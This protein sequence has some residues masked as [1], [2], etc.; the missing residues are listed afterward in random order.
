MVEKRGLSRYFLFEKIKSKKSQMA[1]FIIVALVLIGAI[2]AFFVLRGSVQTE[3]LP[4]D[5]KPVYD[6]FKLCV[7][8]QGEGL[9]QDMEARGGYLETPNFE[10]G[11]P[12][13]PFSNQL[14]F[15]GFGVPY[16]SYISGN[17]FHKEQIPTLSLMQAD[18][19]NA[20]AKE[21]EKC[22]FDQFRQKGY[23]IELGTS[24]SAVVK[25]LDH[26][27][28]VS[29]NAPLKISKG[30][31]S[32]VVNSHSVSI[33][34]E[35][36]GLYN[37]AKS[38]YQKQK[39]G[40]IFE[41][42]SI[43]TLYNYAPVTGVE[44][45]CSPKVWSPYNVSSIIMSA[46][47]ANFAN[48]KSEGNYYQLNSK[49]NKYFVKDFGTKDSINFIV[50]ENWPHKIEISPVDGNLMIAQPVG[51]QEG[52]GMLGF[53]YVPYHFVYTLAFP[54]LVQVY[55]NSEVFQFPVGV[56]IQNNRPPQLNEDSAIPASESDICRYKNTMMTVNTYDAKLN[57]VD[58]DIYFKCLDTNCMI[59]RS[60]GGTLMDKFPQC[61]NG[62]IIAKSDNYATKKI[63]VSTNY[64]GAVDLILDKKYELNLKVLVDGK[65]T[66]DTTM[67]SFDGGEDGNTV[68]YPQQNK[69]KLSE[70]LYNI[71]V[72]SFSKTSISLASKT[73][74]QCVDV[75][76]TGIASMFGFG[77]S[78]TKNCFDVTIP[79][80]NLNEAFSAGGKSQ[81]YIFGSDLEKSRTIIINVPRIST[82]T[83]LEDIQK[84]YDAYD[85][86]PLTITYG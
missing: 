54:V 53:C 86:N 19:G 17:G 45:T 57:P 73:I 74:N 20:I 4:Q 3:S 63:I 64:E 29:L 33:K 25:I 66:G 44:L 72:Q 38:V 30:D 56:V 52:L 23:S 7:E 76:E 40:M 39:E 26:S 14:N 80:Q 71:S 1:I 77:G 36:G 8:Y 22:N 16:W 13:M 12:Y 65:E 10:P 83:T 11:S 9:I 82:P 58:A 2:I 5:L 21:S 35:L 18:L 75:P 42:F 37:S 81:E 78:T 47:S 67:V 31:Q 49:L 79:S 60:V 55:R 6:Y 70:G 46:L 50:M 84:N 85:N 28:E 59:G 41:N 61:I 24:R 15:L 69:V 34:T 62:Y 48:I 51:T 68:M 27:V 32:A 43:D